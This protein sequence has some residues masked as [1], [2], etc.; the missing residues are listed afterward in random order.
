MS[1]QGTATYRNVAVLRP[2]AFTD[3]YGRRVEFSVADLATLAGVYDPDYSAAAVNLDHREHGPALG[4]VSDLRWDGEFLRA[5]V[6]AVPAAVAALID[7]GRLPFRS[8]EVYADLDGRGPYLRGVALLGARPPAVKGLPAWPRRSPA[9]DGAVAATTKTM[10]PNFFHIITEVRMPHDV[11]ITN[12]PDQPVPTDAHR[13]AE[14]NHRLAEENRR[15]RRTELRREVTAFLGELRDGGQLTPAMEQAGLEEALLCAREQGV[16]VEFPDGRNVPLSGV[17]SEVL[18]ALPVSYHAQPM[19]DTEPGATG[20]LTGDER[21]VA[22]ALGLTDEE[23]LDIR[24]A[25]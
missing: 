9:V 15:L 19:L 21:A 23:Y 22:T 24:A 12:P 3:M 4:V 1:R 16:G 10:Q 11:S 8:A 17:L 13:L 18:R 25:H 6:T 7:A 20:E 5:D 14:E 2:G